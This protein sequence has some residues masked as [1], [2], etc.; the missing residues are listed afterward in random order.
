TLRT[1]DSQIPDSERFKFARPF[2]PTCPSCKKPY[3]FDGIARQKSPGIESGLA[4][5]HCGHLPTIGFLANQLTLLIRSLIREYYAFV[6]QCDEPSCA[7]KTRVLTVSGSR[8]LR[9]QCSGRLNEIFSDKLLYHQM[10]YFAALMNIERSAAR[11]ECTASEVKILRD[12]HI[13]YFKRLAM[14]VDM[15]LSVSAR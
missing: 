8:C 3:C 1:L 7:L 12:K 2:T 10:Q 13:E 14:I 6:M 5:T 15:H 4:C 11:L 9:P